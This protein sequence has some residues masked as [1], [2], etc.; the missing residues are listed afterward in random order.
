MPSLTT[1]C[2]IYAIWMLSPDAMVVGIDG[3][4]FQRARVRVCV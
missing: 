1:K 2:E 4:H 3:F